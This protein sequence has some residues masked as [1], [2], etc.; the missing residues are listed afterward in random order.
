MMNRL[1]VR[2]SA[3][4]TVAI[5]LMAA[6]PVAADSLPR[7]Q[8][9]QEPPDARLQRLVEATG[10]QASNLV[11]GD[12]STQTLPG[13]ASIVQLKAVDQTT[14]K[15]IGATFDAATGES[16]DPIVTRQQAQAAWRAVH[17]AL[18]PAAVAKLE[19]LDAADTVAIAIWLR[20]N[21]E[22]LP[23]QPV[24][25]S[26]SQASGEYAASAP[27]D[28]SGASMPGVEGHR[29][30]VPLDDGTLPE[31]VKQQL[32]AVP[33][34]GSAPAERESDQAD[35]ADK[36]EVEH[37]HTDAQS[38]A[39][40][41]MQAFE[42]AN[43]A[44]VR[45]QV[46]TLQSSFGHAMALRG[47]AADYVSDTAPIV[48][49]TVTR[50]QAE[51]LAQL[52]SV[53]AIYATPGFGA[54]ELS[55]AP[56]SQVVPPLHSA[57]Y[58][59]D[60]I[61]V[62]VVEGGR[63][64]TANPYLTVVGIRNGALPADDHTTGVAGIIAS[65][66]PTFRGLAPNAR[67]WSA[68]G[69]YGD[70]PSMS[71]AMDYG[72]T[73]AAILNNSYFV[74][75]GSSP[76]LTNFDRHLDYIVRTN[77]DFVTK[78]AGN[79]G[80][81]PC[82]TTSYVTSPGK[83]WNVM[84]VGNYD[85]QDTIGWGDDAMSGC[86]SFGNPGKDK[87][88]VAAIGSVISST[89]NTSIAA[90]AIGDIGSGTSFAAP[91]VAAIAAD[92]M[93]ANTDLTN[94]PEVI[95]SL[96]MATALH[97]IEGSARLSDKDGV[98]GMVASAAAVSVERDH[99]DDRLID[100][101]TTFPITYTQFVYKGERVRFVINWLANANAAYTT[102]ALPAD[103][104]LVAR[105]ADDT[106]IASSIS[107]QN[108]FEIVDFVA[109][110]SEIYKFVVSRFG[111]YTGGLT[112]LGVAWWRGV[113]RITPDFGYT[114]PDA[115]PLGTQLAVY[116]DDWSP[117]NYWRVMATRSNGASDHDLYL[118]SASLFSD[119]STRN[120]VV[121]SNAFSTTSK[122]DYVAV[123]GNHWSASAPE[124]YIV[125][126]FGGA[127]GY[128]LTFSNRGVTLANDGCYGPY[129]LG[130]ANV[131]AV[132]D[133]YM[134]PWRAKKIT[135]VPTNGNNDFEVRLFRSNAASASTHAQRRSSA[136]LSADAHG[137]GSAAE[138]LT[139]AHYLAS[140]D[141]L[142]LVVATKQSAA[143][144]FYACVSTSGRYAPIVIKG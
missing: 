36:P 136:L 114:D 110:A 22:P 10:T 52:P 87:P 126:S 80:G 1:S 129:S 82:G 46:A 29:F 78:S 77:Y 113:Y 55:V 50:A 73:N 92:L 89:L 69:T 109:P 76:D 61:N 139:Y 17:G 79:L 21:V 140:A 12:E 90:N 14:G 130:A 144:G 116:P 45:N 135:I 102:D 93:D 94:R 44:Y 62:A 67:I 86:S 43:T 51:D 33:V 71:A 98:G 28:E 60:N 131:A 104:D 20:G 107:I 101:T 8:V 127:G 70:D 66:H 121:S 85:D 13:G 15:V 64:Y 47:I 35:Q 120:L 117:S 112:W 100:N 103:L 42:A 125:E 58:R 95:K 83:G 97:N 53:E 27:Q 19:R 34:D 134:L 31:A 119:P 57:G 68:N 142:G 111:A 23:K 63:I 25:R 115:K 137:V 65:T 59:G 5:L 32:A 81:P 37:Q 30:A 99:W 40:A 2:V 123:D 3:G 132:F 143:T 11:L 118:Y 84:T 9:N 41:A 74:E 4:L 141:F 138:S 38:E 26:E 7:P 18:V 108:G 6:M 16:V 56:R 124:H 106:F 72:S 91:M 105:R 24:V 54:H 133:L 128:N 75:D 122:L 39:I 96:I 48:Y 49:A 88:E